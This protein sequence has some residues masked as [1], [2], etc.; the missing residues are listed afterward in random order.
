LRSKGVSSVETAA[1]LGR[2]SSNI[3]TT[4]NCINE[5]SI[6]KSSRGNNTERRIRKAIC[7]C[8]RTLFYSRTCG[9]DIVVESRAGVYIKSISNVGRSTGRCSETLSEILEALAFGF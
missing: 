7:V 6:S 1:R 4:K 5:F 3:D 9:D 8:I 2:S